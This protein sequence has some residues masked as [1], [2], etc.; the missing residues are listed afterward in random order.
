MMLAYSVS[1][2]QVTTSSMSGKVS[3]KGEPVVGATVVATHTP[4]GTQY[5]SITDASGLYRIPNMRVG[6]PYEI[7]VSL[8]GY[9]P[10]KESG[11]T[12]KLGE[13]FL[14]NFE[15]AEESISLDAVR[16]VADGKNPLLNSDKNGAS[17]NINSTQLQRLP[18]ISRGITD[19]ASMTPQANGTSFGGRDN[20]MNSVTVDGAVFNQN[21]GLST[22]QILPGGQAQ[23][24][25]LDAID[26]IT[27]NLS[28]F[29]I[30]QSQFTGAAINAVTKS[31]TNRF[32]G[33]L[34]TYQRQR[35]LL[36]TKL[37]TIKLQ[38]HTMQNMRLMVLLWADL[39]SRINC[40]S[41]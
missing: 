12:L 11:A 19:F 37:A 4:S 17:T 18:S 23:P 3:E 30:K 13:N 34:Y 28:P 29:D 20:R 9:K 1:F 32:S 16:I 22:T 6:G 33:S 10:V 25:A 7:E 39:S 2:A 36:V 14:L 5:Y 24:I 27:V 21:F 35:T 31:G 26:E 8:L 38:V 40:S 15:M 41:S